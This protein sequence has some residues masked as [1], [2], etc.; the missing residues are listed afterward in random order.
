MLRL[1]AT[2][3]PK[4]SRKLTAME[5]GADARLARGVNR[6]VIRLQNAIKI[7]LSKGGAAGSTR[8]AKIRGKVR[9]YPENETNHLRV[10]TGQ[11]RASWKTSAAARAGNF[12]EGHVFTNVDYARIHEYGGPA[13]SRRGRFIMRKRPYVVP[14]LASERAKMREDMVAAFIAP[15]K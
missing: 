12:I 6:A 10:I 14:A 7:N 15:M 3:T 9:I 11:L 4:K 8:S 5:K 1:R 13:G 2:L